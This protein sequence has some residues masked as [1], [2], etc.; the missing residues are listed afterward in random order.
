MK[1]KD[2]IIGRKGDSLTGKVLNREFSIK[3]VFGAVKIKTGD[4]TWI[5]FKNPPRFKEDEIWLK[6]GDRLSGQIKQNHIEFKSE[7]GQTLK[8]SRNS[9]HTVIVN[10]KWNERGR[11]LL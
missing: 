9:I 2:M 3:S 6:T 8:I 4:I 11:S 7:T 5:H 1:V 10:Q